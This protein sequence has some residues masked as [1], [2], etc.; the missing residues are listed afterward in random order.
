MLAAD[1]DPA[2]QEEID[3]PTA[4]R[5]VQ[6]IAQAT[7]RATLL[8]SQLL[9][10]GRQQV[11]TE[12]VLDLN[13]R[14][15][16]IEPMLQP[17]IGEQLRLLLRLEPGIG[18]VRADP[19]Q[20]DQ[21]LVNLVVNARD[22]MP[23]GGTVTI[24]TDNTTL[25]A[26]Y[27]NVRYDI[28]PG[29]YVMLVVSDNGVGM[30]AATRDHI[31]EPFFTT[32]EVGKGTGLGLATIYGIVRQAGGHIWLYSEPGMGSTFKLFFPRDD[33]PTT[34]EPVVAWVAPPTRSGTILVVEDDPAVRGMTTSLLQRAGYQVTAVAD[35]N[36]AM[37]VAAA[38]GDRID[39]LVTDVVM[40]GMS[41]IELAEQMMDRSSRIGVVLLSGYTAETLDLARVTK[42]RAI[43][44]SKP[45]TSA[46]LLDAMDRAMPD[47][48]M[49]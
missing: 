21:I 35:A 23:D 38:A 19:G 29:R 40:P 12:Q 1:L 24:Q 28:P 8:T 6:A 44:V 37:A 39:V 30:D 25:D 26:T 45:V 18:H 5:S 41:G 48:G 46:Q 11:V 43:F 17:L 3:R 7:Q 34:D 42:R 14:I 33:S 36:A 4:L 20:L 13:A 2:A 47:P 15:R 10:F 22:A 16:S 9:A 49:P 27:D 31:F 32:K